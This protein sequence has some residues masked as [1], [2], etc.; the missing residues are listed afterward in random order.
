MQQ[1]LVVDIGN[2]NVHFGMV[3]NGRIVEDFK[4]AT[5]SLASSRLKKIFFH[6]ARIVVCSVVP[7]MD[8]L[9]KDVARSTGADISFAGVDIDIPIKNRYKKPEC[10]GK[11]RLVDCFAALTIDPRVRVVVDFGT[12]L[13]FDFISD[14][15]DYIGGAIVPGMSMSLQSLSS[16]CALLPKHISLGKK[17]V[18]FIG[19]TTGAS[20][21]SGIFWGYS[22]IFNLY[23]E[24]YKRSL[25]KPFHVCI[26]GG[27]GLLM[28]PYIDNKNVFYEPL[29][30]L[31]GLVFLSR[32][33]T[34]H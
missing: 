17:K 25:K 28:K 3:R 7:S 13:T 27:D 6:A 19:K 24:S 11:D 4:I 33:V 29:L 5:S 1:L 30:V 22:G 12:A 31:K 15:K 34:G 20:I 18:A 10:V 9:F 14:K 26:T 21:A 32:I 23:I 2:T 8:R 16:K